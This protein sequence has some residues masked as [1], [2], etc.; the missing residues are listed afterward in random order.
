M[1]TSD[2]SPKLPTSSKTVKF[3]ITNDELE[4]LR[5]ACGTLGHR[6]IAITQGEDGHLSAKVFDK[7][8][9]NANV[10]TYRL[11]G[12]HDVDSEFSLVF[13]VTNLNVLPGDYDVEIAVE[14]I[15]QFT[16]TEKPIIYWVGLEK[17]ISYYKEL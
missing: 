4:R 13:D 17:K 7:D 15:S 6:M 9:S 2:K 12:T 1:I 5:K 16:H 10:F 11:S 3:R 8:Q 14:G